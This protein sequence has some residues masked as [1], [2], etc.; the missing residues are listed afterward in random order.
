M[1]A[2]SMSIAIPV[3]KNGEFL[4]NK[5]C[6]YCVS[7][8]TGINEVDYDT[9]IKHLP[10]AEKMAQMTEVQSVIVTG[11]TEP[12]LNLKAI[13]EVG[14][15]FKNYPL[16]IQ[17]N[18]ILLYKNPKKYLTEFSNA[19]I[20]TVAISIDSI[21][22]MERYVYLFP[23]IVSMG[24]TV[25]ITVNLTDSIL[26]HRHPYSIDEY[27]NF[28]NNCGITELSFRKIVVPYEP[29][30]TEASNKA[31]KWIENNVDTVLAD[32]FE[33]DFN[34]Y[35]KK[36]GKHYRHLSFGADLY[37]VDGIS[38]VIFERCIQEDNTDPDRVRSI[39]YFEDGHM[40]TSWYGSNFGRIF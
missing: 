19:G 22:Q 40:S 6:P 20:D 23:Y 21:E 1:K 18:G 13:R 36:N 9:F 10:K 7:K 39:I 26:K 29:I 33:Q 35:V 16:E 34:D 37:V 3:G 2:N 11:K 25:R 31:V 14:K 32:K 24:M 15:H 5:D 12:T 8:M 27:I 28:C 38:C 30:N 17:T 4:C